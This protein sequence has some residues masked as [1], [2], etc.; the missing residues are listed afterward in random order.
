MLRR[1]NNNNKKEMVELVDSSSGNSSH[2]SLPNIAKCTQPNCTVDK[3]KPEANSKPAPR[4]MKGGLRDRPI[5]SWFRIMFVTSVWWLF[6]GGFFALSFFFME[7]I[8]YK[9]TNGVQP[10]FVRNFLK[11][12]G[13]LHQPGLNI[14]CN[15]SGCEDNLLS[16]Q[17]NKIY[18]W[19]PL[20]Y[21]KEDNPETDIHVGKANMKK[22]LSEL[23]IPSD[24][25]E[26]LVYVTCNGRKENDKDNLKGMKI[27]GQP[28]FDAAMFPWPGKESS[29]WLQPVV[30]DV[31]SS[32]VVKEARSRVL[33]FMECRAWA[34]NIELQQKTVDKKVPNG[35]GLAV[36]CF[37]NG[38]IINFGTSAITN[39][40]L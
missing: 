37:E 28:G 33:V 24:V 36:L 35:G 11:Y 39:C 21:T 31:G 10:Y 27:R 14:K 2:D 3:K 6:V 12:P 8:L 17:I 13:I 40:E 32:K 34:R 7:E 23:G 30:V 20:T 5:F 25:Q 29:T 9:T 19:R 1:N 38:K 16:I 18:N 15:S 22:D 26:N 4:M